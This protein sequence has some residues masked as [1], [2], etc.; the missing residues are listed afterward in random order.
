MDRT[1]VHIITMYPFRSKEQLKQDIESYLQGSCTQEEALSLLEYLSEDPDAEKLFKELSA[2]RA[3]SD[4]LFFS[5]QERAS[6]RKIHRKIKKGILRP[7][8]FWQIGRAHV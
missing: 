1:T 7:V 4:A 2:M 3:V 5:R 6:L 8:H